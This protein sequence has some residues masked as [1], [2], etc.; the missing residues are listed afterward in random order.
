MKIAIPTNGNL[1]DGH[2]GHC[3]SFT[4]FSIN[5]KKE[6]ASEEKLTPPA[7]CGCKSS[8]VPQL[9]GMGVKLLLAGNIGQGAINILGANGIEVIRGCAGEPR[10]A[11]K[12]WLDG[13]LVDGGETCH[14]HEGCSHGK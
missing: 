11:V 7:G 8:I 13:T 4:I 10:T 14:S 2:F 5:E 9:A 6:I 1:I 3:E 12:S